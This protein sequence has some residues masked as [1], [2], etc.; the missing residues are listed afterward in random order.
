VTNLIIEMPDDL[1]R[2]L[3]GIAAA[4]H[5]TVQQF[6]VEKL[7]SLVENQGEPP[8]GSP[9]AVL[10]AMLDAPHLSISDIDE[11]DAAIAAGRSP[12]DSRDLFPGEFDCSC[13]TQTCSAH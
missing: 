6:A 11:F 2:S 10:R 12:A 1:A 8:L 7:R 5:K 3:A 13:S 4:E 9:A